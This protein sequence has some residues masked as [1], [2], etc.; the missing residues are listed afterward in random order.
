MENKNKKIK[1]LVT[2]CVGFIGF[3]VCN[4]LTNKGFQVIGI[5]NINTYYDIKLKKDRLKILN[6]RKNF[7]FYKI[8]ISDNLK[9]K[10]VFKKEKFEYVLHFAAQAGVRFSIYNPK[11]YFK[12]NVE[13]FFN[14]INLSLEK[15]IKHFIFASSSSVY[16][17]QKNF[18]LKENFNTDKPKSFYAATKKSNEV[19]AYSYSSIYGMKNTALRFFTLYGTFGRP[20]MAIFKFTDSIS[21]NKKIELFNNGN[22]LRDFTH[23]DTFLL[24]I[25]KLIIKPGKKQNPFNVFNVG[26]GK[27]ERLIKFI[28]LIEKN[29]KKKSKITKKPLQRGDVIKTH[30]SIDKITKYL[31]LKNKPITKDLKQGIKEYVGWYK[32]YYSK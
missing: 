15:K 14:M 2:G 31:L 13:G 3:H 24:L 9:L 19:M 8:D 25:E 29:L 10:K 4:F 12:S 5:D 21:K 7:N 32:N 27:S 22:H 1:I 16:G 20:D 26:N 28:N 18:P 17:D 11:V 23:I 30:S 6:L